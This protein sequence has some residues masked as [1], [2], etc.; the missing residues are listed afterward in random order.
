MGTNADF[1]I[2][3]PFNTIFNLVFAF[4]LL[5]LI[6]SSLLLRNKSEKTRQTVL[7]SACVLTLIGFLVYKY[8]LSIDEAFNVITASK[9][10][11]NWW[12]ELPL[13]MCNINMIL[14]PI[15]VMKKSRPLMSFCFFL[16]PLGAMMALAMPGI[17]F[18]G[19]SLL[20]PRML[21]YY[22]THFMVVIEGLAIVTYGFFRPTFRDL[23]R[24]LLA[25]VVISFCIFM[26]NMLLRW[27]ELHPNANYFFS[28]ETEGNFLLEIFHSWIPVAF[29]YQIPCILILGP[30]MLLI[31]SAFALADRIR[32]KKASK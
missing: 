24:T 14:I 18:D 32:S 13:Q 1:W 20:L 5:I 27:T 16:G 8:Y 28:V 19:Y 30:Y 26:F 23:P 31:T 7:V 9:G 2:I 15:A 22:G 21:G 6:L 25:A 11:F 17:G 29:L 10:G 3:R 4:F 12:G